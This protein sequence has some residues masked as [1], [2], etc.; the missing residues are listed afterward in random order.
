MPHINKNSLALARVNFLKNR[1]ASIP[2][3][4][5]SFSTNIQ[6]RVSGSIY[7]VTL[8]TGPL[9]FNL[10]KEEI[11]GWAIIPLI[12]NGINIPAFSNAK[13]LTGD[14][15]NINGNLD[16]IQVFYTG[17]NHFYHIYSPKAVAPQVNPLGY[18][19]LDGNGTN[20]LT[21]YFDFTDSEGTVTYSS[22]VP[23][24][25]AGQSLNTTNGCLK[26]FRSDRI[27]ST[28]FTVDLWAKVTDLAGV[29]RG[30]FTQ[31]DSASGKRIITLDYNNSTDNFYDFRIS[32]DGF[33]FDG[34]RALV[35]D[36]NWHRITGTFD[37]GNFNLYVDGTLV[38]SK[39]S[40]FTTIRSTGANVRIG[41][42][43]D[44]SSNRFF[45]GLID[46]VRFYDQVVPP[47]EITP[48]AN[49][50]PPIIQ[51]IT[52]QT[53]EADG[54]TFSLQVINTGGNVTSWSISGEP[55][56]F[57]ISNTGLIT[58]PQNIAAT[59]TITV[60]AT[61]SAGS[62][63]EQFTLTL[64]APANVDPP[65][66]SDIPN[67]SGEADNSAFSLQVVNTGGPVTTWS[68]ANEP[69]GFTIST[70]GLISGTKAIAAKSTITVTATNSNG[71]DS[72]QF[73]LTLTAPAIPPSFYWK[74]DGN[75]NDEVGDRPVNVTTGTAAYSSDIPSGLTGQSFDS[76]N[77]LL[78]RTADGTFIADTITLSAW[79]KI[80]NPSNFGSDNRGIVGQWGQASGG[81]RVFGFDVVYGSSINWRVSR[82][83]SAFDTLSAPFPDTNW[84]NY[85]GIYGEGG[86]VF[87]FYIDGVLVASKTSTE[88]SLRNVS[89]KFRIGGWAGGGTETF[90][91]GLVDEVKIWKSIVRPS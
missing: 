66:L 58:G 5:P 20:E 87:E 61:N 81:Q 80:V 17:T 60:T 36:T 47:G 23:T 37:N 13:K 12:S 54:S 14:F 75:G 31:W 76:L 49:V 59:S 40:S 79:V 57:A 65:V 34:V 89:Q 69:S 19:K 56:G 50:D 15:S 55:A 26:E 41:G 1:I 4:S 27:A 44:N 11:G 68:L 85:V 77:G 63:T 42:W 67:Q 7:P 45:Q 2:S 29:G 64:T 9:S 21:D 38:D 73:T 52:N 43:F 70:T 72:K 84:H 18:W 8:I 28:V 39:T 88:I 32:S 46:E 53:N 35:N 3:N 74:L 51:S 86:A 48:P 22:D 90:F 25:F 82:N 10:G 71:T 6:F 16:L 33:A 78:G 24:G 62:D 30:V 83:G 91:G